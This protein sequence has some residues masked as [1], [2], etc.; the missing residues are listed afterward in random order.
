MNK[1][2]MT[3]SYVDY[4]DNKKL[5]GFNFYT[6]LST[7]EKAKFVNTV[8]D[9]LVDGNYNHVLRNMIFDFMVISVFTDVD[10]SEIKE[11]SDS[12]IRM[13]DLLENTNIVKIVEANAED[14]LFDELNKAVDMN[15]EYRTGIRINSLNDAL[16]SLLNTIEKKVK[17]IDTNSIMEVA[18][19]LNNMTGELTPEGIV[20]ALKNK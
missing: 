17:D 10:V 3:G 18:E 6:N 8:T 15:I 12:L 19:K 2:V 13:E 14:G 20:R 7:Y 1:K 11:A 9:I 4:A 5:V 16:T